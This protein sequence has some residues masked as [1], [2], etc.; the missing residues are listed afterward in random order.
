MALAR[1]HSI[2]TKDANLY[3]SGLPRGMQDST[4]YN[5]VCRFGS[6]VHYRLLYEDNP[7]TGKISRGVGF[8]RF[9]TCYEAELARCVLNGRVLRGS[10]QPLCVRL[11]RSSSNSR[12][13]VNGETIM[14]YVSHFPETWNH[15]DI[16][17]I[18]DRYAIP[19]QF[20]RIL[21]NK[22]VKYAFVAVQGA[23]EAKIAIE[24]LNK[25]VVNGMRLVVAYKKP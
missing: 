14:L 13:A 25:L 11:A 10:S 9:N 23:W 6:I 12:M 1:K 17:E 5:L 20:V 16:M 4:F 15:Y 19:V 24:A 3:I 2:L 21:K 18:F 7:W 8:V 22:F